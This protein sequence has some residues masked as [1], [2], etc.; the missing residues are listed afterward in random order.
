MTWAFAW[1][2]RQTIETIQIVVNRL[3]LAFIAV[4]QRRRA[5]SIT[6][7]ILVGLIPTLLALPVALLALGSGFGFAQLPYPLF[8]VLHRL[9][10]VFPLH[11]IASGLALL[12]IPLGAV[13]WWGFA[14]P[15]A[16]ILEAAVGVLIVLG[17]N[18]LT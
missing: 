11:M 16:W 10:I 13:F 17:W 8:L 18:T 6:A 9:P 2:A 15:Y 14:L 3:R 12:L 7:A 5:T 1:L 4:Q